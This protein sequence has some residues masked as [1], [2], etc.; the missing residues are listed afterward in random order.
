MKKE[1]K[2][3]MTKLNYMFDTIPK[4]YASQLWLIRGQLYTAMGDNNFAK[5][6]FKRA[7]KHDEENTRKFL[8]Q[9]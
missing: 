9:K 5:K 1:Y 2:K 7:Y 8:D 4:K 6:D 3:A